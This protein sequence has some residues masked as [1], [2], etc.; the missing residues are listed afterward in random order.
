MHSLRRAVLT[1][2]CIL[3]VPVSFINNRSLRAIVSNM[4]CATDWPSG[5][6]VPTLPSGM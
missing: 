3:C 6:P 5:I 1:C 2:S 4:L